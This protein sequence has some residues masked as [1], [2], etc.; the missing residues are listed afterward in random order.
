MATLKAEIAGWCGELGF[1]QT[2]VSD[3]DLADAEK[4]LQQ[5]LRR[6]FHGSMDYMQRHGTKRSR[7][8]ELVPGTVRVISVRMDYLPHEQREAQKL[9][10]H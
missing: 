5:W 1:Q 2:G 10:D 6:E 3:V 7:P 9:L 4:R 8:E